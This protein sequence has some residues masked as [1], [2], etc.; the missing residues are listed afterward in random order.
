M[1]KRTEMYLTGH[2]LQHAIKRNFGGFDS[3][4]L[5]TEKIFRNYLQHL[6]ELKPN[7]DINDTKV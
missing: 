6:L 3:K 7:Y 1:C 5:D 2:Q 4:V